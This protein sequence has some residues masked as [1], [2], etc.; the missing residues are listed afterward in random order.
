MLRIAGTLERDDI[1][2]IQRDSLGV[3]FVIQDAGWGLEASEHG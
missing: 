3:S 2:L 1:W